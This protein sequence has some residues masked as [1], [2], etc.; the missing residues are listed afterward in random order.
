MRESIEEREEY[1]RGSSHSY[2]HTAS[3]GEANVDAVPHE[4]RHSHQRHGSAPPTVME[5]GLR[6]IVE[7][8]ES[9]EN[10]VGEKRVSKRERYGDSCPPKHETVDTTL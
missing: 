8:G 1:Y 6:Y 3:V 5:R 7:T 10:G 2:E 9:C 4:G